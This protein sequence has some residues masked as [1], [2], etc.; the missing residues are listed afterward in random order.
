MSRQVEPTLDFVEAQRGEWDV[1][2]VGAG[3]AGSMAARFAAQRGLRVLLLDRERFPRWKV[4]GCCVNPA[5]L[6]LLEPS[7]RSLLEG[8]GSRLRTY[9]LAYGGRV[10]TVPLAGGIS[11]SRE[12][13]DSELIDAAMRH[14]V[15]FL[16]QTEVRVG[17]SDPGPQLQ[18]K[19]GASMGQ[20]RARVVVLATGL[21]GQCGE[22]A[23]ENP[24][25]LSKRSY[26]GGGVTLAA[27]IPEF[28]HG[29]VSIAS[30]P[31]GYVGVVRLE[32]GRLDL[33][34][35]LD[36]GFVRRSGGLS[37]AA[38]EVLAAAGLPYPQ[39]MHEPSWRGTARLTHRRTELFGTGYLVVGDAAGYVEPFTGEGIAWAMAGGRA[40]APFLARAVKEPISVVGPAW[41]DAYHRLLDGRM[42]ICRALSYLL[43]QPTLM[44]LSM[45]AL[46]VRP[47]LAAWVERSLSK[48]FAIVD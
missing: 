17:P 36:A 41:S 12:F 3:P 18:L 22:V 45:S 7:E 21:G 42:R 11:L 30:H 32:D 35:A 48:P 13:L 23:T 28:E 26:I 10:S 4:C 14:G 24:R 9:E 47:Q 39:G 2:V 27:E 33:A 31:S 37:D 25:Q 38:Q 1:I 29:T 19:R 46:R 20:A 44:S 15:E 34:A 8:Q 40:I 6:G 5:A 43:R 16:D